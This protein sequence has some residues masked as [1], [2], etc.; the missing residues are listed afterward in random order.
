MPQL[1]PPC[2]GGWG[3][4]KR[5]RPE[6]VHDWILS[7]PSLMFIYLVQETEDSVGGDREGPEDENGY[8]LGSPRRQFI[9]DI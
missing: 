1:L 7:T 9:R 6:Q 3:G 4:G 5:Q 2:P 8:R